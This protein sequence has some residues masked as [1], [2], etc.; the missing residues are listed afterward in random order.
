[1]LASGLSLRSHLSRFVGRRGIFFWNRRKETVQKKTVAIIGDVE[2][3]EPFCV[4]KTLAQGQETVLEKERRQSK[5][6]PR[7]TFTVKGLCS[8]ASP[9]AAYLRLQ[10]VQ[11][12]DGDATNIDALHE[13]VNGADVVLLHNGRKAHGMGVAKSDDDMMKILRHIEEIGTQRVLYC[14]HEN[15]QRVSNG[16]YAVPSLERHS[17]VEQ[18]LI[19][20]EL[21]HTLLYMPLAYE[22][23]F[24]LA[25]QD[26]ST[27]HIG[28]IFPAV[29]DVDMCSLEDIGRIVLGLVNS[30]EKFNQM[31]VLISSAAYSGEDIVEECAELEKGRKIVWKGENKHLQA[32]VE[33]RSMPTFLP[34][35][36][37]LL[38]YFKYLNAFTGRLRD[39]IQTEDISPSV[40]P[41]E[42]WLRSPSDA[43]ML[44][45]TKVLGD[46]L[47][48][49]LKRVLA[50][51]V[52]NERSPVQSHEAAHPPTNW[53]VI[54]KLAET[55]QVLSV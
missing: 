42:L 54:R 30:D 33:N 51:I 5:L 14:S 20:S 31:R 16:K 38:T 28:M 49:P 17:A 34:E 52:K 29:E 41:L 8:S 48:W 47:P 10:G 11:L 53:D 6:L 50:E 23:L 37:E 36:S 2:D 40:R 25:E 7:P 15:V 4:A 9:A 27:G 12:V 26:P 18:Y 55:R 39:P 45:F 32:A 21:R 1:M 44:L 22:S 3:P 35:S 46:T 13:V 43:S 19:R 24:S